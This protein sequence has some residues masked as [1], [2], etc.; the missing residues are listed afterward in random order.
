MGVVS[1]TVHCAMYVA[2][3]GRCMFVK[4]TRSLVRHNV[5]FEFKH[6]IVNY[7]I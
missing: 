7:M 6:K 5:K 2:S 3:M 1:R 4:L